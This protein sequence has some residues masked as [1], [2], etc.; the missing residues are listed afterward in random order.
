M[1][2]NDANVKADANADV[3]GSAVALPELRSGEL[4]RA[5]IVNPRLNA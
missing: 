4:K 5:E 3:R 1:T 2:A